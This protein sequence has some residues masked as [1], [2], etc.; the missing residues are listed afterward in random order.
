RRTATGRSS[1]K[2]HC[3]LI[4]TP[5]VQ[6]VAVQ[7]RDRIF[8]TQTA[9]DLG[10]VSHSAASPEQPFVGQQRLDASAFETGVYVLFE[11]AHLGLAG[12]IGLQEAIAEAER[13]ERQAPRTF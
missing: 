5:S 4:Q 10:Q 1:R 8:T 6:R 3:D 7:P 9:I 11:R 2:Q 13:A 12:R